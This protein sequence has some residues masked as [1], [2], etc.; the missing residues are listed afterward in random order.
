MD[1][2]IGTDTLI[3]SGVNFARGTVV[4]AGSIV[5]KSTE[6]YTVIG[7]NPA[8]LIRKRFREEIIKDL[9]IIDYN[10]ISDDYIKKNIELYGIN[11]DE[12]WSIKVKSIN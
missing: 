10:T 9:M 11:V 12:K 4:G 5:T 2:W 7:G 3:L 8:K 6:P 1:V